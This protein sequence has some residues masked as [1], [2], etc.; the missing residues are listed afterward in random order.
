MV[1]KKKEEHDCKGDVSMCGYG[2]VHKW[3]LNYEYLK[4]K[5]LNNAQ[6]P[7]SIQSHT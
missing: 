4:D 3:Y 6:E 5:V 1:F 2:C 7:L